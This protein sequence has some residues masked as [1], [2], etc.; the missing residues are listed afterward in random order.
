[1]SDET[2]KEFFQKKI[3]EQCEVM[4]LM[5][6]KITDVT[7]QLRSLEDAQTNLVQAY[8]ANQA[9]LQKTVGMAHK[10]LGLEGEWIC[11]MDKGQLIHVPKPG[12]IETPDQ[13]EAETPED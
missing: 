8:A 5:A 11:A 6:L 13:G 10:M 12:E 2:Q 7:V 4:R 3:S 9:E 1:M